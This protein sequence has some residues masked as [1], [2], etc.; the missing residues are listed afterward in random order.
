MSDGEYRAL[1]GKMDAFLNT[2]RD[3]KKDT[4]V[5]LGGIRGHLKE[6]NS[7]VADHETKTQLL[8]Q[9]DKNLDKT[10]IEKT[11]TPRLMWLTIT[12]LVG[13][14]SAMMAY[15]LTK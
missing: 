13:L 14:L 9:A 6:L 5:D 12:T 3:F 1:E 7:K 10:I 11:K 2:L 4:K 15:I 8:E